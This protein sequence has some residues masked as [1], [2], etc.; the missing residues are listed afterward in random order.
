MQLPKYKKKN[1]SASKLK[2]CQEPGCGKEFL[3]HPIS[4]YCELHR[5]LQNRIRNKKKPEDVQVKNQIFNHTFNHPTDIE[6]VCD[7]P[8]CDNKFVVTILPKQYVYPKYCK[9]H[10]NEFKRNNFLR[11]NK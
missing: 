8:N 11:M 3:G 4:K 2:I 7:L 6:F 10:R 1:K 5:D 9:E